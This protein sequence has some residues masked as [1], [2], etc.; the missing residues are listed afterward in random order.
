MGTVILISGV[1]IMTFDGRQEVSRINRRA[2][3][4]ALITATFTAC[5]A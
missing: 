3:I 2:I 1:I 4:Y 5:Y